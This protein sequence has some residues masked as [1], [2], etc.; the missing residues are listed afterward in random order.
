MVDRRFMPKKVRRP[1]D[2][3]AQAAGQLEAFGM[4]VAG[5]W[6][7]EKETVGDLDAL[8]WEPIAE[9]VHVAQQY[10]QYEEIRGGEMKSEGIATYRGEPLL[11]NFWH[12]PQPR[13]SAGMLLFAT[14][15]HDLNIMMRAKAKAQDK[16]LSQYGLFQNGEQIDVGATEL[17]IFEKLG[18]VYLTPVEREHWRDYLTRKLSPN[19]EIQVP[20]SDGTNFYTVTLKGGKGWDCTCKGFAYRSQCRHLEEAEDLY[21]RSGT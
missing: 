7:R 12:V 6:R 17:D 18:M 2:E 9:A 14:G 1:R 5:S 21:K 3:M 15:P 19:V 13:A 16:T 4:V 10:F 20:S 8:T 11:L